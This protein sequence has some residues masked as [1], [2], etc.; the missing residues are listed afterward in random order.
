MEFSIY[1]SECGEEIKPGEMAYAGTLGVIG[2]D[3]GF[4]H[5]EFEW[6]DVR[7]SPECPVELQVEE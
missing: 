5:D 2:N 3:G 4:Y 7:H 6:L 1:C